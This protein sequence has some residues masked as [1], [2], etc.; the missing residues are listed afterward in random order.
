MNPVRRFLAVIELVARLVIGVV[1]VRAGVEKL[2]AFGWW[3]D[4]V[5]N[6]DFVPESLNGIASAAL[7]GTEIVLGGLLV[8][9]MWRR[10]TA[11]ITAALFTLFAVV[12]ISV[13]ARG[14]DVE[15]GCFGPGADYRVSWW[16]A[17]INVVTAVVAFV[18]PWFP[19]IRA[20]TLD[21]RIRI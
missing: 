3:R 4:V 10:P 1:L 14:V 21:A 13:I 18:V 15:C 11:W 2:R 17:A 20:A 9:G 6:L 12:M 8:V 19:V 16:H 5:A 7:P